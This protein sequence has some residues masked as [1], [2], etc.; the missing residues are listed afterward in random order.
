MRECVKIV[1]GGSYGDNALY[2]DLHIT[3]T[4]LIEAFEAIEG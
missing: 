3:W 4:I 2:E 1:I